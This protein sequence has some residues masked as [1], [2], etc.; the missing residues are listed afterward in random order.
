MDSGQ[1][2]LAAGSLSLPT[3]SGSLLDTPAA[4]GRGG[5]VDI[6]SPGAINIDNS[7]DP[8][9]VDS[10]PGVL[11]L[12][13]A[14]LTAFG[15]ESLL[16]GGYRTSG[17][18]N[19]VLATTGSGLVVPSSGGSITFPQ[20]TPGNDVVTVSLA[21]ASSTAVIGTIT[22]PGGTT[23]SVTNGT[24]TA[25]PPGGVLTL[26][27]GGTVTHSSGSSG[28]ISVAVSVRGTGVSVTTSQVT[29]NNA[30]ETLSGADVVLVSNGNL[31]VDS[32]SAIEASASSTAAADPLTLTGNGT[33]LRVSADPTAQI[34]RTVT[35]TGGSNL[36]NMEIMSSADNPTTISGGGVILDSTNKT[37]LASSVK[38]SG[39]SL[40]LDSG[41]ISIELT[42]PSVPPTTTGLIL[43]S[44]AL[45]NLQADVQSLSLLSYSSIDIYND[46]LTTPGVIGGPAVGGIY[47]VD[48]FSLHATDIRGFGGGDVIISAKNV[49]LDNSSGGPALGAASGMNSLAGTLTVDAQTI[50]LGSNALQVDQYAQV[51]LNASSEVALTGRG[52]QGAADSIPTAA[53]FNVAGNLNINTPL[54]TGATTGPA[55]IAGFT[56]FAD[57]SIT[58]Q[59]AVVI[60]N[61]TNAAI[62]SA[63]SGLAAEL[64]IS[65]SSVYENSNIVLHSGSVTLSAT[66]AAGGSDVAIGAN[67][68]VDVSGLAPDIY[69]LTKYTNGGSVTLNS[70]NG[71]VR[72]NGAVNVSAASGTGT[73]DSGAGN[74]GSL[75]V[76]AQNGTFTPGGTITGQGGVVSSS[77]GTVLAQGNGG[78]FSLDVGS[79]A[80]GSF[81]AIETELNPSESGPVA[82]DTY[83]GGFTQSQSIRVRNGSIVVDG[84]VAAQTVNLSADNGYIEVTSTGRI[85]AT[86]S[87]N[88]VI[89]TTTV[90][91]T[92]NGAPVTTLTHPGAIGG[93]V[94]LAA[95]VSAPGT[96]DPT[97]GIAYG[98]VVLD[99]GSLV[100]AA[101]QGFNDAG[102]GGSVTLQAGS[103]INGSVPSTSTGRTAN[104]FGSGVAVVN[105]QTG[106]TIDLSV[107]YLPIQLNTSGTSSVTMAA[108]GPVYF[109]QGTP[110]NDRIQI[111]GSGVVG[112]LISSSGASTD[113]MGGD[114]FSVPAGSTV[115][116]SNPGSV[117]AFANG[118]TGGAVTL[119]L[120]SSANFTSSGAS[121][122]AGNAAATAANQG[123]L[124]GTLVLQAPQTSNHSDVQIDPIDGTVIQASSIVVAGL[125]AQNANSTTTVSLDGSNGVAGSSDGTNYEAIATQNATTFTGT[126][127]E[128]NM[129]ASLL[130]S[131][132]QGLAGL[133]EIRPAEEIDNTKGGLGLNKTW[134]F[135]QSRYGPGAS[136]PGILI[137]R[138]AGNLS[139][140]FGAS[141]SDGFNT[142]H[143]L[144]SGE[145]YTA[146]LMSGQ[147]WSYTLV[148]GA[149]FSSANDNGVLAGAG[150][151]I[152]GQNPGTL[153]TTLV[154]AA[155]TV[156][157]ADNFFQTI[158]TGT[159]NI[160]IDAGKDVQILN[161]LAT[162]YTAGTLA[163]GLHG[164]DQPFM[165]NTTAEGNAYPAQYSYEGGNIT[166]S[167]LGN[168]GHFTASGAADSAKELP[169]SWLYRQGAT[170]NGIFITNAN[171][172]DAVE[173]T[174]W[175][176]DFSNFLEGV[177]A[178]GGGNVTLNAGGNV[179]NID[180][181][182]PTNA[183]MPGSDSS[184]IPIAPD[185]A[186]LL[187][188]GGGDVTVQAG[189]N[190]DA[191]VY[192]VEKGKGKLVAGNSIVT[193]STRA[194]IKPTAKAAADPYS[195][196]PTTLFAGDASFEI[197][198]NSDVLLGPV[199]NPFLLPQNVG[200]GTNLKSY[201]STYNSSDAVDIAS[202]SGSITLKTDSD[203]STSNIPGDG[204][205]YSWYNNIFFA[206]SRQSLG[207]LS[208][209]WLQ[210]AETGLTGEFNTVTYLMPP[211]LRATA[212]SGDIDLVGKLLLSPSPDG[213]LDLVAE[214][215]V[216]G[217]QPNTE[218]SSLTSW[219]SATINLSDA[220]PANLPGVASP[221]SVTGPNSNATVLS[222]IDSLFAESG[223]TQGLSLQGKERLHADIDD[224]ALHAD[225]P[226]PVYI[227][228]QTGDISGLTLY[229]GKFS[230]I[231][232]G[233]D[234]NDI[235]LYI[236][237][238]N[239]GDISLVDAGRNL[240][241]YD[242]NSALRISAQGGGNTLLGESSSN[243]LGTNGGAPTAGD[244]QISGPGTMEILAGGN[245]TLGDGP[246]NT[247]GPNGS[248]N[249]TETGFTSVGN[250][251]NSA[252]PPNGADIVTG[253]GLG[254]VSLGLSGGTS[255]GFAKFEDEFLNPS[256]TDSADDPDGA[257]AARYL[258]DLATLL[259]LSDAT[260][261]QIWAAFN[262][263]SPG[264]KD[265]LALQ[266]YYLVLRDAGRDHNSSSAPGA[267]SYAAANEA[268]AALFPTT[269]VLTTTQNFADNDT[270]TIG[271]QV[272]T[273]KTA[274]T[275][276]ANE[277]LIGSDAAATLAN[278]AGALGAS[279]AS[280]Q[281][282]GITYGH[283]T[284]ANSGIDAVASADSLSL[285][286]VGSSVSSSFNTSTSAGTAAWSE[287]TLTSFKGDI[288]LSS[289][290]IKTESGGNINLFAPG[291]GVVVG[292][293]LT[294]QPVDQGILTDEGGNINIFTDGDVTVGTSRIFTLDGG[295]I[296]IYSANGNIAAG[297]SSK[298]VQSA[299]PTRV[300]VDPQS[301]AVETDLAGLATGG[302]IGVLESQSGAKAGDVDL[303]APKGTVDAGDAGIRVSG[304]LNISAVHVL[305]AGNISVGGKSSGVP[306]TT[307][308]SIAGLSAASA[309]AGAG[310]NQAND[311]ARQQQ[312]Q[313]AGDQSVELPSIITVEVLGYGGGDD[314]A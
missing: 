264:Q 47:P 311:M 11:N 266:V 239:L 179:V 109:P 158:R 271:Q 228:A 82:G 262:Q 61:P 177:G 171:D 165:P 143:P 220:D 204:S 308:P 70:K 199:A 68:S 16:I 105:V 166:I 210:V 121:N 276:A 110:G 260:P 75:S 73:T 212:Y 17:V 195:W 29:V 169:T 122:L 287:P 58:A 147:S 202:L 244:I 128:A 295:N 178:L 115:S 14:Q 59:G 99:S 292:F 33:L 27:G 254:T 172:S 223:A 5:E 288:S 268:T 111:S 124:S 256:P 129:L 42:T 156:L 302:G 96:I 106:A 265:A 144:V 232:A 290:E 79:L 296:V 30:G 274:L 146:P 90:T 56:S 250:L 273:L 77:S 94:T 281:G 185:A 22:T 181:V 183:R 263:M 167:A 134:D 113:I 130:G 159:G 190:I 205:L 112:H 50:N 67:G 84:T 175:W 36:A 23:T 298:T 203:S 282:A 103:D 117:I 104:Q 89:D 242:P 148:A 291:G 80:P 4:G 45:A 230:N 10:T 201:F 186:S 86:S 62:A 184:G 216:N 233:Q 164:F 241:A 140:A 193:N 8:S 272:Y 192:Y 229:S 247:S 2:I 187:E 278:L 133:L 215:S 72:V 153:P 57:G 189:N 170:A 279:A 200:N 253:A 71:N 249:G 303:I 88:G 270:I 126:A 197:S 100:S 275:G 21:T 85:D 218:V 120:P 138:A 53:A 237:N 87:Q 55:D 149:D 131:D 132:P 92:Q 98:S 211:T 208:Q 34:S 40:A 31:F 46:D 313:A 28:P 213:T 135:S 222:G 125:F 191:G 64:Q 280:G 24:P 65:G 310:A 240:T 78:T 231:V 7:N 217:V 95:G 118:G 248:S 69:S 234:I 207:S 142:S 101:G 1:L 194:A 238:D 127:N 209:P 93:A 314:G 258:P 39:T 54:I 60:S 162:I 261:A 284:V 174:S 236:Q 269:D 108:P 102:Q 107:K 157:V 226:N 66:G 225:D 44:Q 307:V 114:S 305:N 221:L 173:S 277:V 306:T 312:R 293:N 116:L 25:I 206:P 97:S 289:R 251:R 136:Q 245:I 151:F 141:I 155:A 74:A 18:S 19:S 257:Q 301:G 20:G 160:T 139:V 154:G 304:N 123:D 285:T 63:D 119:D 297:A 152:L 38:L 283:G 188:L 180:A 214:G 37:S 76:S 182:A 83:V 286:A 227:Y 48:S 300:L 252:L 235:A 15:A 13:S 294:D 41:Q 12:D 161:P 52:S 243:P 168:I 137:L 176:V 35:A 9:T 26:T 150:S 49:T 145:A 6:S 267:A 3:T 81:D 309:A 91:S 51:N 259:G 255:L 246:S 163:P 198:A 32:G 224:A 43:S 299:P 219:G 196:L